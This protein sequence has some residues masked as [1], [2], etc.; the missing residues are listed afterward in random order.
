MQSGENTHALHKNL[1]FIR[2][3]SI[4]ILMIHFYMVCYPAMK[5]WGISLDFI[6]KILFNLSRGMIFLSGVTL[7][8]VASIFLLGVS[9]AGER[10]KKS[11]NLTLQPCLYYLIIGLLLFFL[12]SLF[13]RLDIAETK[14]AEL[15]IS[16]TVVGYISVLSGGAKLSRLIYL[17][18]GKDTFNDLAE[19]FEQEERKLVNEFSV[20]LPARYNLRGKIR[21]SW[22]NLVSMHR[23]LLV[24]GVPGSGKS[25]YIVN[26]VIKQGIAG[27]TCLYLYDFKFPDLTRIA[28]NTALKNLD[29]YAIPPKFYL[30][31]FDDLTRS[32]R[33]NLLAP[34]FM[35]D[36]TDANESSRTIML[37]LN[38]QWSSKSGEFFVESPIN[39]V[40]AVFWYLKK[41][42]GGKYCTLPHAIELA[43][44]DY[45]KLFPVM[46][47]E[48]DIEVL[49]N[50]FLSAYVHNAQEQLEGQIASA[51]IGLARLASPSLYYI[52]SGNDFTLD[53]NNP[54]EPKIICVGNNPTKTQIYGAVL[55]LCTE[56][57]L[58][59][60]NRKGQ[61]KSSLVFDEF[62]TIY[63]GGI[64]TL[65]AT[66]RSNLVSTT[67]AAQDLSQ[68]R[69]DY[70]REQ[71]EVISNICGNIISGQV[72]GDTAKILS[73]R[74]GRIIQER[75]SLNINTNDTS[76]TK[77]FQLD[78]AI[79]PSRISNLSAGEFVGAVADDPRQKI[80]NK[81]FHC[82]ILVDF[83]EIKR[84]EST[85]EELP[86]IRTISNETVL[87]N[88][89]Q[90]KRDIKNLIESEM[91]KIKG[92]PEL[93]EFKE[94]KKPPAKS[95]TSL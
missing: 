81:A 69:K 41:Y 20:N 30:I 27:G 36:I 73:E 87:D 5:T 76:V 43:Q 55:S 6:N 9:L 68:L 10:G 79:P 4:I 29:K 90:I 39:F 63:I 84:V 35:L 2:L 31:N 58:K 56:R 28:Y 19:T 14:L 85:Y 67:L 59:L 75:E 22:I 13:L 37:S 26:S 83:D 60:V 53:V 65:I 23:G 62:P 51:K 91:N 71:A 86:V 24:L 89:Y 3:G 72:L 40:T 1:E 8:K 70:G 32:H 42:Q 88:Y 54:K 15:Y 46:S 80:K 38:K 16:I 94:K 92:N 93:S 52:L 61:L 57:M 25:A 44:V 34:E 49:I 12:S 66:A 74:I 18:L 77:S 33:C 95:S 50:P 78:T 47:L 64:D 11:E 45:D 17:K 48:T 82:E 7:P 21:N